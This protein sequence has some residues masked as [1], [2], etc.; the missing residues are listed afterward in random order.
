MLEFF[1]NDRR[2]QVSN[3]SSN[4]TLLQFLRSDLRQTG[5]KEGCAEGDCGACT[6]AMQF[7]NYKGENSYRSINSCIVPLASIHRRRLYTVEGLGR[8][9]HH[10]VQEAMVDSLGSQCGYCTPGFVMSLFT[11]CYRK[12]LT[13]DWQKEDQICGNLCR[14]TGYRPIRDAL[15]KTA[16]LCPLDHFQKS[17]EHKIEA[18]KLE[19]HARGESFYIPTS[20]GELWSVLEDHPDGCFVSGG[21]DLGLEITKKKIQFPVLISLESIPELTKIE[22]HGT[23]WYVGASVPLSDLELFSVKEI[24]SLARMLRYFGGRQ[25]KNRATLGGNICTA[26]PIGDTPPALL[27][28]D[29]QFELRSAQGVRM[30]PAAEFFLD[31]RQTA[32]QPKE[33]LSGVHIPKPPAEARTASF[34]VSKR[35][36]L[37]ISAVAL[38]VY[39]VA[40]TKIQTIRLAY[41]G[42]AAIPKRA[43]H[44]EAALLGKPW[45]EN[46][47]LEALDELDTDFTPLTDHRA[48][49]W[50]RRELARNLLLGFFYETQENPELSLS[51]RHSATLILEQPS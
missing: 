10:P 18:R 21:T 41:G 49:S 40:D 16:G 7:R 14:C 43:Q 2:I 19:Y 26:S 12:D 11:A 27:A 31:Y 15:E 34:K 51:P 42:M 8:K 17:L 38:S 50:Y 39:L 37:D 6:V 20:F 35:R 32:L 46:S 22:D 45:T 44:T 29:A 24:P 30:I 48:S 33:I 1:L 47:I 28:L 4:T 36:E 23:S 3:V 25:I 5:T 9:E 13:E